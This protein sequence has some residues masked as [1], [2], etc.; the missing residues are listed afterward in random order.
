[1]NAHRPGPQAVADA[2]RAGIVFDD[3]ADLPFTLPAPAG[4]GMGDLRNKIRKQ[5]RDAAIRAMQKPRADQQ[6]THEPPRCQCG[7]TWHEVP[8]MW[9]YQADRWSAVRF[10]CPACLPAELNK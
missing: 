8:A 10:Y 5:E 4:T 7:L 3:R 2:P 1:M 6:S 9:A